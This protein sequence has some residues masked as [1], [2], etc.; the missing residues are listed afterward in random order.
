MHALHHL[1]PPAVD[2]QVGSLLLA[3]L[4]VLRHRDAGTPEVNVEVTDHPGAQAVP[5]ESRELEAIFVA[6]VD[7]APGHL[8][9][10]HL[11]QE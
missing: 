9:D 3:H 7:E 2:D 6:L 11:W 8:D 5:D 1:Q 10:V 4:A